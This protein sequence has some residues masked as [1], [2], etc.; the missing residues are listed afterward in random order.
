[1]S[2]PTQPLGSIQP[3]PIPGGCR[4]VWDPPAS[5]GSAPLSCYILQAA[6]GTVS[7]PLPYLSI[8]YDCVHL[9]PNQV[10][11]FRLVASNEDGF[12][13]VPKQYEPF[14]YSG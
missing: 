7:L 9:V 6:D 14:T 5:T 3:I 4:L 8:S 12:E 1:M 13:S 10:Y 11:E 2:A